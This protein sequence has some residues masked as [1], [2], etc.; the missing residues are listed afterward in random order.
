VSTPHLVRLVLCR[1][2]VPLKGCLASI[3]CTGSSLSLLVWRISDK[4]K[5]RITLKTS[6][7]VQLPNPTLIALNFAAIHVLYLSGA[8]KVIDSLEIMLWRRTT[9]QLP[10]NPHG[11][12][13]SSMGRWVFSIKRVKQTEL[14]CQCHQCLCYSNIW[15]FHDV[16]RGSPQPGKHPGWSGNHNRIEICFYW[17]VQVR[18]LPMKVF[19]SIT[20]HLDIHLSIL[21]SEADLISIVLV[22]L[23]S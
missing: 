20:T 3:Q 19:F 16:F 14:S 12:D 6:I 4:S 8:T 10:T 21:S 1:Q 11:W 18:N 9:T 22:K 13:W 5:P 7:Q 15:D 2:I 17:T 23:L